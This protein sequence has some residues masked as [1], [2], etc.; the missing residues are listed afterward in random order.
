MVTALIVTMGS[1]RKSDIPVYEVKD[2]AVCFESRS[3][4]F[5]LRGVED[6]KVEFSVGVE[7]IGPVVDYDRMIDVR[8]VSDDS[9]TDA[10]EGVDFTIKSAMVA[11]GQMKGSVVLE[12]VNNLDDT[13]PSKTVTLEIVPNE[14]F[15]LGYASYVRSVIQWSDT[16][17]RP[18]QPVWRGWFLYFS[19][20]YSRAIHELYIEIF[21]ESIENVVTTKTEATEGGYEYKITTWWYSASRTLYDAVQ[22][23]DRENPDSPLMHSDDYMR[24]S[25]YETAA[26]N[27][28]KDDHTPTILETLEVL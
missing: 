2:S 24:Y 21:G 10:V 23:H 5:S 20:Y 6:E 1:C 13:V 12:V 16:Y 15:R 27:G 26:G 22:Q 28:E 18:P 14:T 17:V 8:V 4:N 19:H 11:A 7:M 25:S 9:G 3:T